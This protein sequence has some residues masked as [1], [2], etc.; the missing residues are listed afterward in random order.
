MKHPFVR[1]PILRSLSCSTVTVPSVVGKQG[2]Y[3]QQGKATEVHSLAPKETV[4]KT[5]LTKRVR[6]HCIT[7]PLH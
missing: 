3:Q 7:D 2:P 4:S 6:V 5:I 1:Y